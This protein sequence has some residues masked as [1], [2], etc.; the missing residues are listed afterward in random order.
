M[1]QTAERF[2][3][4]T[5]AQ[6]IPANHLSPAADPLDAA[7]AANLTTNVARRAM[8]DSQLRTS[9]VNAPFALKRMAAVARED[10]VPARWRANAYIDRAI[11]LDGGGQIAAPLFYGMML[12]EADPREGEVVLIVDAGSGYL[13]ALVEPMVATMSVITA[14]KALQQTD[15]PSVPGA[16]ATLLLIDGAVEHIPASLAARLADDAR[17]VTGMVGR[18][19]ITRLAIGRKA[20]ADVALLPLKDMGIPRLAAFDVAKGWSF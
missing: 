8:I 7:E 11:A 3:D 9:G 2:P 16:A 14:E 19:G 15:E 4:V 13:P 18:G 5:S 20:G 10:H 6:D 17:V 1:S 12:E